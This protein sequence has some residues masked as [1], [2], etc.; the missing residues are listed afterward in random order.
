MALTRGVPSDL[1]RDRKSDAVDIARANI[2]LR[3]Q[4][5]RKSLKEFSAT[6]DRHQG[7]S[8]HQFG[9]GSVGEG[10]RRHW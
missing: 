10:E 9:Q 8:G 4:L 5:A 7:G 2:R 3:L 1:P 6:L